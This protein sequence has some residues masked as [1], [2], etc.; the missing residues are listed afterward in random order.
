MKLQLAKRAT[1]PGKVILELVFGEEQGN[2][3]KK[4]VLKKDLDSDSLIELSKKGND[5]VKK[6]IS[7]REDLPEEA[8]AILSEDP[9]ETV[10]SNLKAS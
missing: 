7:K 9:N 3:I 6:V 8:K 10:R 4:L 5:Y 1:I 2:N